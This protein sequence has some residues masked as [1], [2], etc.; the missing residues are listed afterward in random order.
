MTSVD[1]QS[2]YQ[3]VLVHALITLLAIIKKNNKQSRL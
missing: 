1:S 2:N 3:G